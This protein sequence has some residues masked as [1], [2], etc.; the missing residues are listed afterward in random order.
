MR[1]NSLY[2]KKIYISLDKYY[3]FKIAEKKK[4]K[5]KKDHVLFNL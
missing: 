3:F 1:K 4:K 5:K 2:K